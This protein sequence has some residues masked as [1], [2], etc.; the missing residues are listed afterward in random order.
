MTLKTKVKVIQGHNW[1]NVV[2]GTVEDR[3]T[4]SEVN[5]G[6]VAI[7]NPMHLSDDLESTGQGHPKSQLVIMS[8]ESLLK[9]WN[10]PRMVADKDIIS[11]VAMR[12]SS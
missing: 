6:K 10:I 9:M 8:N 4:I 11:K 3:D 2:E 5:M 1:L 12:R 7:S